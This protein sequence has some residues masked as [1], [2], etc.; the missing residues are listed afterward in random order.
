VSVLLKMSNCSV[1]SW[2]EKVTFNE[3]RISALY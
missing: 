3:M 2:R 1:I